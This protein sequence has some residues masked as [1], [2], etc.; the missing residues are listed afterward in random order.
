MDVL[1]SAALLVFFSPVMLVTAIAVK[2]SSPGPVFFRQERFGLNKRTFGMLKFRS[3][4]IDAE[5]RQDAVEHLNE[6]SGPA[7]KIKNDPRVTPIWNFIRKMSLDELPQLLNVF[8]GELS[9]F[10]P[11]PLPLRDVGRFS[12]KPGHH[13]P[14]AD[15][16]SVEHRFRPLD[17]A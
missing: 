4:M 2:L 3:M 6:T 10:G 8:L 15:H 1:L 9:L 11:R 13:V 17:Q 5:S 12:V 16:G 14:V 7:F